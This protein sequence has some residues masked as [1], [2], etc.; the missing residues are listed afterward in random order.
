MALAHY[1][2]KYSA[3][4]SADLNKVSYMDY[5]PKT[6]AI[7]IDVMEINLPDGNTENYIRV[8]LGDVDCEGEAW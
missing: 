2:Q 1:I 8:L 6:I 3:Y 4:Q 7:Y 5:T